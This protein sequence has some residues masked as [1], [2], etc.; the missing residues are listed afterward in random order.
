MPRINQVFRQKLR[1]R[2]EKVRWLED[3]EQNLSR[4]NSYFL[5]NV[6]NWEG[7]KVMSAETSSP[8]RISPQE[9]EMVKWATLAKL[10]CRSLGWLEIWVKLCCSWNDKQSHNKIWYLKGKTVVVFQGHRCLGC[11]THFTAAKV[12]VCGRWDVHLDV[13]RTP[14][15]PDLNQRRQLV[16]E[17]RS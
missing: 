17:R 5:E 8:G 9:G 4:T 7:A 10:N 12:K 13:H 15:H 6:P 11:L 16:Y 3:T 2:R 14:S 1:E